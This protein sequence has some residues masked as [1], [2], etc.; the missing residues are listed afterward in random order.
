MVNNYYIDKDSISFEALNK[1]LYE[2]EYFIRLIEE[3][4][5]MSKLNYK[6]IQDFHLFSK[7]QQR[8]F[9]HLSLYLSLLKEFIAFY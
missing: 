1:Y 8:L 2:L 5:H 9:R 6:R 4:F 3:D 7:L